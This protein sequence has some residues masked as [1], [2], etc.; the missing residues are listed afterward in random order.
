M[1]DYS[2]AR[3]DSRR[4]FRAFQ[5][6]AAHGVWRETAF[7]RCAESQYAAC[8]YPSVFGAV[9]GS[10]HPRI[11]RGMVRS[12]DTAYHWSGVALM[13]GSEIQSFL[14]TCANAN[15]PVGEPDSS[16]LPPAVVISVSV[17]FWCQAARVA[18]D[19][20]LRWCA[21]WVSPV[22]DNFDAF[23]VL[24][25]SGDYLVLKTRTGKGESL[26]SQA[27]I[28]S[29]ADRLERH[30]HDLLGIE[31]VNAPDSR[32]WTRHQAWKE[33]RKSVV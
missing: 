33:D 15:I 25:K 4:I 16:A 31:F 13:A 20:G 19:C 5:T 28:F 9:A 24:E 7:S 32:R 2:A 11:H 17:H 3:R 27:P 6:P 14:N 18:Q 30:A 21:F 22:G 29:A 12:G 1:A 10:C 26:P 8:L 23:C